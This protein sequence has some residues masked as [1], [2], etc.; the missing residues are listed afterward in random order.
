METTDNASLLRAAA[1]GDATAWTALV[2]RF[3]G[4]VWSVARG[5]G[6]AS[7]DAEDV[8]QTTWLR[9][10]QHLSGIKEPERVGA[11]LAVTAR[12]ESLR[13]LRVGARTA[14]TSDLETPLARL[15]ATEPSPEDVALEA[16]AAQRDRERLRQLWAAF[17]DLSERCRRLLRAVAATPPLSYAEIAGIF[18]MPIG[19]IGPTRARCLRRLRELM[20]DRGITGGGD[21]S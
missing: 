1:S 5:H 8:F 19:S 4:L 14:P 20:A 21:D 12:N 17:G 11:W 16:E 10:T 18:G 15:V 7:A 2:R 3:S 13:L 9:L 6:L